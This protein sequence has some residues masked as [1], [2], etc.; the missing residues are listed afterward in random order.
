M[1]KGV[2]FGLIIALVAIFPWFDRP[3]FAQEVQGPK[4]LI[5]EGVFDF[6]EVVEGEV[7]RHSFRIYN[8][9]NET[10]EILKVSPG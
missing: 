2:L 1:R 3:V 10:L 9:G 5:P 8:K 4:A 6:Q 7:I